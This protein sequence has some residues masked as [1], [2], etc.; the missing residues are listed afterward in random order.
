MSFF[1][2]EDILRKSTSLKR[3][4]KRYMDVTCFIQR[5]NFNVL[6]ASIFKISERNRR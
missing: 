6:E 1:G 5:E 4:F 2:K 3:V